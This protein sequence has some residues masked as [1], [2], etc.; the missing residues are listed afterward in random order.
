MLLLVGCDV[1][2]EGLAPDGYLPVSDR[3][4]ASEL[5]R[6]DAMKTS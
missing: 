5:K 3:V 6:Y 1:I 4:D 2:Q